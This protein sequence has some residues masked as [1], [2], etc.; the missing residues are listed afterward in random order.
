[1]TSTTSTTDTT[2]VVG[3]ERAGEPAVLDYNPYLIEPVHSHVHKM[4]EL[5]EQHPYF[6]SSLGP[7]FWN[8]TRMD[9]VREAF[10]NPQLF[11]STAVIPIEPD[12]L[13]QMIPIMLDPPR[14]TKWR[15]LT[16]PAFSPGSIAHLEDKVRERC[17]ELIDPLVGRE[18]CDF[19]RDF[20]YRYPTTIFMEIMGLPVAE[21]DRFLAWEDAILHTSLEIDPERA[22]VLQ[23]TEEVKAYFAELIERRRADPAD[24]LL[25]KAIDWKID[26]EQISDEDMLSFCLLMFMA[27]LDTVSTQLAYSWYHLATHQDDLRRIVEDPAII[28]DALEELLRAYAFVPTGRK[29]TSDVDFHGCPM[30]AGETVWLWLPAACRD[31]RA[32]PEPDRVDFDRQPNNHIAFGAGPHR[33]LGSHLARRELRI[34]IEEWHRRI[35]RYRL[36]ESVELEEHGGMFGLDELVLLLG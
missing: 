2:G 5:R 4:D 28:P 19:L 23:A 11:S 34:A 22:G 27:G 7:G 6:K 15:Q 8:L 20:A 29:V 21:A 32:F 1:M 35:P 33:C 18:R 3:G 13:F 25:S 16:A 10:Q 24:D 9:L 31:P 26:G 14:H 12:P 36:D 30:K 17:V